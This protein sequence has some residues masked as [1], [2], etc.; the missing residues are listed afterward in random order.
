MTDPE[1]LRRWLRARGWDVARAAAAITRH[2][3]WRAAHMPSGRVELESIANELACDK[4]YLQGV[5]RK[6]RPVMIIL[7]GASVK[8]LL[9]KTAVL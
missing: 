1:F 9:Q 2:A 5:D 3:E 4:V 6:G 7:V 8:R